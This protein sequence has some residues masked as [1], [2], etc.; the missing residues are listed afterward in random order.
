MTET[1]GLLLNGRYQLSGAQ[2]CVEGALI[3]GC[4]FFAGYPIVPALGIYHHYLKRAKAVGAT[5]VQMEDEISALAAVLGASWT[6]KKSMTATAGPGFSL[7]MEHLGLGVMLETP[8]VIVD[9]QHIGPGLGLP[10]MPFQGDAMQ[11]RWGSHG[12]YEIVVLAPSSV[13]EMFDFTIK[14]FNFSEHYRIPAVLLADG[15]TVELKE[16]VVIPTLEK[17]EI[18][19]RR[20]YE[21]P[22]DKYLPYKREPDFVPLMVDAGTGYKFHVTGLTHDERG[23]PVMNEVCQEFNVHP[24]VWKIRNNA[25]KIINYT[26]SRTD[27]AEVV[28]VTYGL[29][30]KLA[31]KV[32]EQ[33]RTEGIKA[34]IL[35]LNVIWPFPE[36]RVNELAKKVKGMVVLEMNYG[37]IAYE[38]E[39][40]VRGTT[41]V[42]LVSQS[43]NG[44][45]TIQNLI[46]GINQALNMDGI[47]DGIIG[48]TDKSAV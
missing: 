14:A 45:E 11:S 24:L 44:D 26:E 12:D 9:V 29:G 37:Q 47:Q 48:I 35:K 25:E 34:G 6:G 33:L 42:F 36:K 17:I 27:D 15:E 8:C 3:A 13:Q 46:S 40:I 7:M 21:G 4:R 31:L 41:N 23:Y 32:V 19:P 22:R 16:E 30:F 2:A 43:L 28:I 20:Y 1:Q 18:E 5:Y 10:T 38:V 39:R